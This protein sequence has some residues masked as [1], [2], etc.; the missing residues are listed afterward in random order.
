M[1]LFQKNVISTQGPLKK[2]V[3]DFWRLVLQEQ[4][5]SIV[6]L[7]DIKQSNNFFSY[8]YWSSKMIEPLTFN[9]FSVR[10]ESESCIEGILVR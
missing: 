2:T 9:D 4:V 3:Y 6:M 10:L 5:K 1:P 8:A 7:T